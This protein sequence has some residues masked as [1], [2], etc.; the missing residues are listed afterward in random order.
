MARDLSYGG[1]RLGAIA[2]VAA[3]CLSVAGC[4]SVSLEGGLFDALGVSDRKMAESQR[5]KKLQPRPGI[6]MPPGTERLPVPGSAP[7]PTKTAVAD[8]SF[9]VNPEDR[10]AMEQAKK[11]A[12]H[13]AYCEKAM[14]NAQVLKQDT[15]SLEGPLG[16]CDPSILKNLGIQSPFGTN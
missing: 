9:P 3:I 13:K 10:A 5:E 12:E 11:A 2:A 1:V 8:A 16:R 4:G 15:G 7:D 14:R 6:V